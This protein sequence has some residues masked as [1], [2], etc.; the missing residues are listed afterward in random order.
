MIGRGQKIR[1]QVLSDLARLMGDPDW[2][3]L[4]RDTDSYFAGLPI[5]VEKPLPRTPAVYERKRKWRKY[6]EENCPPRL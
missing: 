5:G 3:V 2:E 1:L 6:D 4:V